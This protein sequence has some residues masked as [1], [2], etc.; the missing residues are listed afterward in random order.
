MKPYYVAMI[1]KDVYWV[2]SRDWNRRLFDALIPLPQGTTY[3]AYLVTGNEKT[4]LIDTVNPGFHA[5]LCDK[6]NCVGD[7]TKIDYM[8]MNHAEPD[9]ASAIP[10]IM[11]SSNS[12]TLVTTRK[13]AEM[14]ATYFK[15]PAERTKI[16]GDGDSLDLGGKTLRFIEAPWLHWPETMFTYLTEDRILF[17]CDFFG[18]HTAVGLYDDEVQDLIPLAQRYFGEIMMP[19]RKLGAKAMDKIK[20]MD[21]AIIAPSHG[22]IYRN[23]QR[24]MEEYRKWTAGETK[25]KALIA[26]ASMWGA[27]ES[28]VKA[29]EETLS[30]EGI[31]T[32]VFSLPVSDVGDIARELVDSRAIVLGSPTLI[33]GM[34]PL[35]TY[36]TSLI[37]VLKPPAKFAAFLGSYGWGGGALRQ[38]QEMLHP[39]RIEIV[40][41][42]DVHGPPGDDGLKKVAE[43]GKVLAAKIKGSGPPIATTSAVA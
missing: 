7:V 28:M 9:H 40:G 25:E 36:A 4:A 26:Y 41:A 37:N 10:V 32:R 18:A 8:I 27:T 6:I 2:G 5:E 19:F 35:A 14:A 3:N 33:G 24:I 20:G 39:T 42:V 23:P 43:L 16:V 34:H 11:E 12:A 21:I 17:P 13:G 31:E 38:A 29:M 1:E 15:V 30:S 22:P